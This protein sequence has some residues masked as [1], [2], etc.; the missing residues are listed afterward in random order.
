MEPKPISEDC[1]ALLDRSFET[2]KDLLL[3][4]DSI[5]LEYGFKAKKTNGDENYVYL[6]CSKSGQPPIEQAD[7]QTNRKSGKTSK[8]CSF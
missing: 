8:F 6:K 4:I 3:E 2:S 7:K 5:C 1:I